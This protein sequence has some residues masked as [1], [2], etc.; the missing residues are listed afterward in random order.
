MRT[1]RPGSRRGQDVI[2]ETLRERRLCGHVGVRVVPGFREGA[3]RSP[4]QVQGGPGS[5]SYWA[6]GRRDSVCRP[7]RTAWEPEA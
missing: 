2:L 3:L 6:R 1:E 5:G 4:R 7:A